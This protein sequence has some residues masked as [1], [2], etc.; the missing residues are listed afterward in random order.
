M[1]NRHPFQCRRLWQSGVSKVC[2]VPIDGPEL[3]L[4]GPFLLALLALLPTP[5]GFLNSTG[6]GHSVCLRRY[7]LVK[8]STAI[9]TQHQPM[10]PVKVY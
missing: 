6:L 3:Q 2:S 5:G 7:A 8:E 4:S 9:R 1:P 10:N